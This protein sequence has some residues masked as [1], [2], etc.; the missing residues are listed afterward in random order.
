MGKNKNK[1]PETEPGQK[2][3]LLKHKASGQQ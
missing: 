2:P 1:A 3:R